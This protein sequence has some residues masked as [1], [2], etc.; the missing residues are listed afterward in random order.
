MGT[1]RKEIR[2]G[3][4][5]GIR[6]SVSVIFSMFVWLFFVFFCKNVV[7]FYVVCCFKEF[8]DVRILLVCKKNIMRKILIFVLPAIGR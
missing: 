3:T 2:E 6:G 7:D 4:W 1:F 5:L 8:H